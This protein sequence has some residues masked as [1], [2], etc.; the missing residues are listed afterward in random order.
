MQLRVSYKD[1]LKIALPVIVGNVAMTV[2]N[3]TDTIFLGRVGEVEL[4]ASAVGSVLFFA[5]AMVGVAIGTGSQIMIARRI[6]EKKDGEVGDI[7]DH[8]FIILTT[9]GLVLFAILKWCSPYF[10]RL[11]LNSQAL[12]DATN[13]F[14]KYRSYGLIFVMIAVTFRSFYVGIALP[15]IYGYYSFLMAGI[16]ILLCYILI[17]GNF[18]IAAMGIAGAGIASSISE[19]IALLFIFI[20]TIVHKELKFYKFFHFVKINLKMIYKI[21]D[22]S[23][24][25]VVQN[26]LSMGAWFIFFVFIEKLGKHELATANII[27]A[28]YMINMTPIWGFSVAANTMVSNIIGQ[29]KKHEVLLL[30]NKII[31][32]TMI[33]A[34]FIVVVNFSIPKI[35]LHVFTND[36]S[37]IQDSLGSFYV[38]SFAMFF[39]SFAIVSISALSGTG[40]TRI[41]L[42]IE[43]VAIIIYMVYNY[44]VTFVFPSKVEILWLSEI[45]Y[46]MFT[47]VASYIY[48]KSRHWE[49]IEI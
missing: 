29:E 48:V 39:F 24:P 19:I 10:L 9:L 47:G 15:K 17:F 49:K 32:L 1:I 14:L 12:I 30:L 7:F 36:M 44:L 42:Y 41:A 3:I 16:N 45:I 38:V 37:L 31:K 26:V 21:I 4:G 27:R 6:G 35:I 33:I 5:F 2:L 46:W 28:G 34:F 43:I 23:L 40:A 18:G 8:S 11:I 25:L 20:Y 22:L 13:E